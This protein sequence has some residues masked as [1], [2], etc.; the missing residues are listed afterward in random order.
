MKNSVEQYLELACQMQQQGQNSQAIEKYLQVLAIQPKLVHA[1]NELGEL[2]ETEQQFDQAVNYY[3]QVVE[4]KPNNS[5]FYARLARAMMGLNN[6]QRAITFYQKA[7]SLNSNSRAWV[8]HG[9]G[10]ALMEDGQTQNAITA[11]RKALDQQPVNPRFIQSKLNNAL[12]VAQE[13]PLRTISLHIKKD[14]PY[15]GGPIQHFEIVGRDTIISLLQNGLRPDHTLL[16][17]GCGALRLGY[18]LIRLLDKGN[19]YGIEPVSSM[20]EAGKKYS[21]G[22]D[23]IDLKQ[24]QFSAN[25]ECD[26]SVFGVQFDFVVARS[27]FTHMTPALLRKTLESFQNNSKQNAVMLASYWPLEYSHEG[28]IGDQLPLT[29]SRFIKVVKYSLATI[30]SWSAEFGLIVSEFRTNPLINE[31]VW[32][33]FERATKNPS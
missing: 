3:K 21:L 31:Q 7:I 29:D 10:D 22:T 27:I 9:L 19:Y 1:L 11:Y 13:N 18:W 5:F 20:I 16:D 23:L 8:Y 25:S 17:F 6:F 30:Q 32:L 24:P 2:Y 12:D 15:T 26:F 14:A 33:K 4:L 28:E